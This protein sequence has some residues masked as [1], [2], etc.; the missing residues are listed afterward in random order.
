MHEI[1]GEG[2]AALGLGEGSPDPDHRAL[3]QPHDSVGEPLL[4]RHVDAA[5]Q[6][7]Q[8]PP[9]MPFT[10]LPMVSDARQRYVKDGL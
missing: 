1:M 9:L 5:V 10:D 8:L 6:V 7:A 4:T 2:A 3:L